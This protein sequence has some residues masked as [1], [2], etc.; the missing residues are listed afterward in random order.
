MKDG[1]MLVLLE[2]EALIFDE[3]MFKI[4]ASLGNQ[5]AAKDY[6]AL[7]LCGQVIDVI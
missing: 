7:Q 1:H 2:E 3:E 5:K 4:S 6:D